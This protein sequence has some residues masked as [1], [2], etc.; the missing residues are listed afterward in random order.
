MSGL[1]FISILCRPDINF[2]NL[3]DNSYRLLYRY[4][5]SKRDYRPANE[6]GGALS[7]VSINTL[8]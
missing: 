2:N 8:I 4:A 3:I 6:A 7:A 5:K 1:F